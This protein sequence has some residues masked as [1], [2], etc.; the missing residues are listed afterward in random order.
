MTT[1]I[2]KIELKGDTK[3][4]KLQTNT[5]NG[6]R[7]YTYRAVLLNKANDQNTTAKGNEHITANI[8]FFA[9][10]KPCPYIA[11]KIYLVEKRDAVEKFK[12]MAA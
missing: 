3:M 4:Q 2:K 1:T 6:D 10:E 12:I 5:W 11:E 7:A 8:T 9:V